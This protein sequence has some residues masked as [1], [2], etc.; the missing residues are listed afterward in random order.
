MTGRPDTRDTITAERRWRVDSNSLPR[1]PDMPVFPKT[2][3]SLVFAVLGTGVLLFGLLILLGLASTPTVT[4]V[5]DVL[6]DA[7][8][9]SLSTFSAESRVRVAA[10]TALGSE[11]GSAS[12]TATTEEIR[13]DAATETEFYVEHEGR[14]VRVAV[15]N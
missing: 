7:D 6:P 4:V 15:R 10:E 12:V 14:V 5:D 8:A 1:V 3:R 13:T 9:Y 11:S 2:V